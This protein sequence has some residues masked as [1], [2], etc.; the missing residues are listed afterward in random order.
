MVRRYR[1]RRVRS[2]P[3][4]GGSVAGPER[5]GASDRRRGAEPGREPPAAR[6]PLRLGR[7][8][9]RPL[10]ARCCRRCAAAV[11]LSPRFCFLLFLVSLAAAR[12]L[13]FP[14]AGLC[15]LG[16]G[17]PSWCWSVWSGRIPRH[18]GRWEGGVSDRRQAED[19]TDQHLCPADPGHP[20]APR[21]TT[22]SC[23]GRCP[24]PPPWGASRR[25]PGGSPRSSGRSRRARSSSK[26]SAGTR[27]SSRAVLAM[28]ETLRPIS[29]LDSPPTPG[30]SK[31]PS[32]SRPE[33][34]PRSSSST[35]FGL[36]VVVLLSHSFPVVVVSRCLLVAP[37]LVP[38][39]ARCSSR[40]AC[41]VRNGPRPKTRGDQRLCSGTPRPATTADSTPRS[42]PAP[43]EGMRT[44]APSLSLDV[45]FGQ[46]HQVVASV[47]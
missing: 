18:P 43:H 47:V 17:P 16:P 4:V 39:P 28:P 42:T 20:L 10:Q 31:R 33:P 6:Q 2:A 35:W 1:S 32:F 24:T 34:L 26:N 30:S 44:R 38:H 23:P 21:K 22:P 15:W 45:R 7:R 13:L 14:P 27:S 12:C 36:L 8:L 19:H 46:C 37:G 41:G 29:P 5:G 40:C 11:A 9:R 25:R 3:A